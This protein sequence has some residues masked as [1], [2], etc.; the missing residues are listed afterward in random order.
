MLTPKQE[1][2]L[3]DVYCFLGLIGE[4][5]IRRNGSDDEVKQVKELRRRIDRALEKESA[6]AHP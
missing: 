3:E 2:L 5:T 4:G 1:R 6:D